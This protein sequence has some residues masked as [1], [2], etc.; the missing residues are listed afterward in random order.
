MTFR[1]PETHP[2]LN[3]LVQGDLAPYDFIGSVC[4]CALF[5]SGTVTQAVKREGAV[6]VVQLHGELG[7]S[8]DLV[9]VEQSRILDLPPTARLFFSDADSLTVHFREG[10]PRW[11]D[12]PLPARLDLDLA[13]WRGPLRE[14]SIRVR[15]ELPSQPPAPEEAA[16]PELPVADAEPS[17]GHPVEKPRPT[18]RDWVAKGPRALWVPPMDV[19]PWLAFAWLAWRRP[20]GVSR[21]WPPVFAA[22]G[23][24]GAFSLGDWIRRLADGLTT[25]WLERTVRAGLGSPGLYRLFADWDAGWLTFVALTAAM[26]RTIPWRCWLRTRAALPIAC[27]SVTRMIH[28]VAG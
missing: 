9:A 27:V 13:E 23:V 12:T 28:R 5:P 18:L 2:A 21:V 14:R 22:L 10:M 8:R 16:A 26:I 1:L 19:L 24:I 11:F 20:F 17:D 4:G 3:A 25:S 15:V 6:A 7:P